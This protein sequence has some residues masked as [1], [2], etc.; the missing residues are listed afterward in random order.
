MEFN[1]ESTLKILRRTPGILEEMLGGLPEDLIHSNEGDESW[2][3]YDIVGHLIHGERT[4]WIPRMEIIL[5]HTTDKNFKP[6]DRFAQFRESEGKSMAELLGTFRNLRLYNTGMLESARL[7]ESQLKM[8]GI[9][10]AFGKVSLSE[11]LATW[12]VHDLNHIGQISRVLAYQYKDAIG[13]WTAYMGI[14]HWK[15][16]PQQ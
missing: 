11:L 16:P 7:S 1:L 15:S 10:P 13:P 6:F 3:P 14:L 4:D 9:H 12:T 2:S 5:G 8:Q